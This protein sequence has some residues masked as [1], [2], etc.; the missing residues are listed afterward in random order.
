MTLEKLLEGF[1]ALEVL[2]LPNPPDMSLKM[3]KDIW[4]EALRGLSDKDFSRAINTLIQTS[5]FFPTPAK[6]I[7]A[8]I[9]T[10]ILSAEDEWDNVTR[11]IDRCCGAPGIMPKL[12]NPITCRVIESMGGLNAIW[13]DH[14]EQSYIRNEFITH[15]NRLASSEMMRLMSGKEIKRVEDK[16]NV[17]N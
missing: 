6:I 16:N 8:A 13:L 1:T 4:M 17:K 5:T 15:Y 12:S 2:R 14:R 10:N 11:E 3:N 9:P 7:K